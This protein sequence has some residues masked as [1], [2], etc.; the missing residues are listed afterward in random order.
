MTELF[1]DPN[2]TSYRPDGV[3]GKVIDDIK[4]DGVCP[5]CPENLTKY[6]K[7]P[8]LKEGDFWLL[9]DNMYP[10]KGAKHH[11]LFVHKKHIQ[12]FEEITNE[13]WSELQDLIRFIIKD[14]N[15]EG[16]AFLFRF[17]DTA[18]TGASVTHLHANLVSAGSREKD[19]EPI[20]TRIG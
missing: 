8:I 3:Y 20:M 11:V 9:T 1:V 5:F 17:G 7:N 14:R 15:I 13:A 4:K 12:R 2:N 18:L 6:H 19:R 10:Y 16:G